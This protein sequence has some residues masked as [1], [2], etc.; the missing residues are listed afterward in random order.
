MPFEEAIKR[1]LTE[2]LSVADEKQAWL[3]YIAFEVQRG[4]PDR[5]RLLYERALISVDQD[6]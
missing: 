4:E 2:E 1:I 5:A 6:L 3:S